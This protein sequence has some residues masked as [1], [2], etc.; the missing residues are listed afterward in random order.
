MKSNEEYPPM[1]ERSNEPRMCLN[2]PGRISV[3]EHQTVPC[4]IFD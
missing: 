2:V 4:I 1:L 3:D